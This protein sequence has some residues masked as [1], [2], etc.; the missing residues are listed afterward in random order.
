MSVALSPRYSTIYT[1][2]PVFSLVLDKDVKSEVAM[3]YPELYKD[4]L[5]VPQAS[6]IFSHCLP[7]LFLHTCSSCLTEQRHGG[8]LSL[9]WK[10]WVMQ[11][12]SVQT[13]N[14]LHQRSRQACGQRCSWSVSDTA[15]PERQGFLCTCSFLVAVNTLLS[16]CFLFRHHG[17]RAT[18]ILL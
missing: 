8:L 15:P 11:E 10:V 17:D 16:R 6:F 12:C 14:S 9:G 5:K 3:L 7:F 1:M 4:L 2:F 18:H 13:A